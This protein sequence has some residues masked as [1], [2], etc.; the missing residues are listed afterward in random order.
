MKTIT[1]CV[2]SDLLKKS[3]GDSVNDNKLFEAIPSSYNIE[4]LYPRYDKRGK[5]NIISITKYLIYYFRSIFLGNRIFLTRASKLAFFPTLFRRVFNLKVII[6][7]GCTPVMFIERKVF[8]KNKN[9]Q[10]KS[11]ILMRFLYFIEPFF[12]TYPLR[13]ADLI[14]VENKRA[15]RIVE[16]LGAE[17]KKIRLN[18]YFVNDY[19]TKGTNPPFNFESKQI[20]KIGYTGRFNNYDLILPVIDAIKDFKERRVPLNLFLIG[21]GPNKNNIELIVKNQGLEKNIFFLGAQPHQ[22]VSQIIEQFHCLVLPM[23]KNITP[24][25]VAIKVLEGIMKGKIIITTNSGNNKK[26]FYSYCDLI[27]NDTKS[28]SI[29][30]KILLV[31]RNYNKYEKYARTIQ[32]IQNTKRSRQKYSNNIAIYLKELNK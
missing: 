11:N 15:K 13:H 5:L 27:L 4:K 24:S 7:S 3:S 17:S 16:M 31:M 12:E 19:F 25:T 32:N 22:K 21:D 14:L 23:L 1:F 9:F 18:P 2:F 30:D 29:H 28:S 26:L 6:R 8:S 10:Q 20:F